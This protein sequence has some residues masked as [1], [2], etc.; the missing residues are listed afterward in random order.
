MAE[1]DLAW[2]LDKK[3]PI[4]MIIAIVGQLA[5]GVWWSSKLDSRVD[6]LE[7]ARASIVK[8]IDETKKDVHDEQLAVVSLKDHSESILEIVRRLE[9]R[10]DPNPPARRHDAP[11]PH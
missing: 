7:I 8:D 1:D 9:D 3:V 2:H 5:L 11:E 10:V 4:A 6:S